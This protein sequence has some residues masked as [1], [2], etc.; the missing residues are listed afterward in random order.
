MIAGLQATSVASTA[1]PA[2][3]RASGTHLLRPR[4][5]TARE[6]YTLTPWRGDGVTGLR[7]SASSHSLPGVECSPGT[8]RR[9]QSHPDRGQTPERAPCAM[10]VT[11]QSTGKVPV[12]RS[13]RVSHSNVRHPRHRRR[14]N[15]RPVRRL[16]SLTGLLALLAVTLGFGPERLQSPWRHH[17]ASTMSRRSPSVASARPRSD[18][19]D[20]TTTSSFSASTTSPPGTA[21][22]ATGSGRTRG[23]PG[24]HRMS[25]SSSRDVRSCQGHG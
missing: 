9:D 21:P 4:Q 22:R 10:H 17:R 24:F 1:P 19:A 3:T 5:A 18:R 8:S 20:S 2:C 23:F 25:G 13:S 15:K 7:D 11:R 6:G 14:M 16:F 12:C